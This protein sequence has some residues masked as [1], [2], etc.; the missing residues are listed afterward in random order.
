MFLALLDKEDGLAAKFRFAWL[1]LGPA[2][3]DVQ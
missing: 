3:I 1:G 2:W